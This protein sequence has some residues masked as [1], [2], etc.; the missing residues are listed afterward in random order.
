MNKF[1]L[2]AIACI[3]ACGLFLCVQPASAASA[4]SGVWVP[5]GP[6]ATIVSVNFSI[7]GLE[8]NW[9]SGD[10]FGVKDL[11]DTPDYLTVMEYS[12]FSFSSPLLQNDLTFTKTG[13]IFSVGVEGVNIELGDANEFGFY[14]KRSGSEYNIVSFPETT[15]SYSL[16]FD[17]INSPTFQLS[18]VSP[19]PTPVP[20]AMLLLGSGLVGLAGLRRKK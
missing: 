15:G 20:T 18:E 1:I 5:N 12:D 17:D 14:F 8:F 16:T 4:Y 2:S 3:V 6:S 13:D 19:V 10:E 9:E 11:S 7:P